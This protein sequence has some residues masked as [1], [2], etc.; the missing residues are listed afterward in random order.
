M[1]LT[2]SGGFIVKPIS[3]LLGKIM[4]W[5]Y[6]LFSIIGIEGIGLTIITFTAIM[7]FVLL[8]MMISQ[9]RSSKITAYIQP[10][11][12]KI[13]K[14]YKGK[15]DQESV[16]A[17]Q[18][19][20]RKLQEEYGANMTSSSC[21]MT[22]IQFPVFMALYSVISNIPAYVDKIKNIYTPI[23]NAIMGTDGAFNVLEAYQQADN[24]LKTV[25]LNA[26]NSNTIIDVLAKIP[27]NQWGELAAKYASEGFN[28]IADSISAASDKLAHVYDFFGVIDL[29]VA[30]GFKLSIALLIPILSMVF[31]F[32]S[33]RTT[34]QQSTGDPTQDQ[35]MKTMKTMMM[36]FP[37][38][39]FFITVN[40]P[41]GL[42]LYWATGSLLSF[43]TAIGINAYY[44]HCDMEKI[45]EKAKAKAEKKRAKR[46]AKGKKSFWDKMQEAAYGQNAEG[47]NPKVNSSMAT[48]SLK[49]Y[50]SSSANTSNGNVQY[51]QGSLASK[52]NIMQRYNDSNNG[53]K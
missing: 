42:G 33:M 47:A 34:P 46:E 32:L 23:S 16:L 7:R 41:A 43:L 8:P 26:N 10:E 50:T 28:N 39:S 3:I 4:S 37:I 38:M 45:I 5:L 20:V 13:N 40:V 15:K 22:L 24:T 48:R 44:K 53:G 36:I 21:I 52:A 14:K 51:R 12:N 11:I 19:E 18:N 25:T 9:N 17:Q 27:T 30:P 1:F 29:T 49:N 2:K 31:Q 6:D 35:T